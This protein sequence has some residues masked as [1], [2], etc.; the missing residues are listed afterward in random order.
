M[1]SD[2]SVTGWIASLK[3]ERYLERLAGL[4]RKKLGGGSRRVA[5]E[6]DVAH[7][8]LNSFFGGVKKGR[9]PK[10]NDRNDLWQ[11]LVMLTERKAIGQI[12]RL[13][14]EKRRGE[15]GES[16]LDRHNA[17]TSRRAGIEQMIGREP[18][19]E[20]AAEVAEELRFRMEQLEDPDLQ[21]IAIWKMEG[22]TNKEIAGRLGCVTR[23]VE[24]R[25]DL[26]RNLWESE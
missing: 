9:F 2:E 4:A 16:A 21:Q 5:D 6:E 10:L 24:R 22:R 19:P 12:R 23:T 25:L 15:V 17:A 13:F 8:A 20:F 3:A 14:S 18:S 26:I 11:I 7:E 1:P